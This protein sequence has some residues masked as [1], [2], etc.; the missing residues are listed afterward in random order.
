MNIKQKCIA[1]ET[2]NRYLRD[3]LKVLK[4]EFS[5]VSLK[6]NRNIDSNAKI[7]HGNFAFKPKK[8]PNASSDIG[9]VAASDRRLLPHENQAARDRERPTAGSDDP[10]PS[11]ESP[12][13]RHLLCTDHLV[14][15]S[16]TR[17]ALL[18]D[19]GLLSRHLDSIEADTTLLRVQQ[20][21]LEQQ[22]S[23]QQRRARFPRVSR[24]PSW[25]A[26]DHSQEPQPAAPSPPSATHHIPPPAAAP[27]STKDASPA[28]LRHGPAAAVSHPPADRQAEADSAAAPA[29]D[30]TARQGAPPDI[31]ASEG[32]DTAGPAG[33]P[34]LPPTDALGDSLPAQS[35]ARGDATAPA[36]VPYDVLIRTGA[37]RP[38]RRPPAQARAEEE[39]LG[40][41]LTD[42]AL[43]LRS[44]LEALSDKAHSLRSGC[45]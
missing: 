27:P 26:A 12:A 45:T 44:G 18:K 5:I 2:E 31:P 24:P 30:P 15:A 10:T 35:L 17:K 42:S 13:L 37:C 41:T 3:A 14:F 33:P 34:P 11:S 4:S 40:H 7:V 20:V 21:R 9:I 25:R 28:L 19:M 8:E 1:A 39:R 16:Y 38:A 29:R 43:S 22:R 32:R 36:A 23:L 6:G